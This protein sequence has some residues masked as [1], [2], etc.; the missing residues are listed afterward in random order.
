[1]KIMNFEASPQKTK[2]SSCPSVSDVPVAFRFVPTLMP[3]STCFDVKHG[4]FDVAK[5]R[6][7]KSHLQ[8]SKV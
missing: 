1:M 8:V 5:S 6:E 4:V 7:V 2:F 3:I